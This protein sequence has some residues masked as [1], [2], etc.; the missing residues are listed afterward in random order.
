MKYTASLALRALMPISPCVKQDCLLVDV[1][2]L[3]KRRKNVN[4]WYCGVAG[5]TFEP[6][7]TPN[8]P[9]QTALASSTTCLVSKRCQAHHIR[10][11]FW[12][13]SSPAR[14]RRLDGPRSYETRVRRSDG[15]RGTILRPRINLRFS[16]GCHPSC[17]SCYSSATFI[18][19]D[20]V[21]I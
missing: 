20:T 14:E 16:Y 21:E 15:R 18:E 12:P 7:L 5:W 4:V 1:R 13:I 19:S 9:S 2:A 17:S 8:S 11:S 6:Q 3:Y 10:R